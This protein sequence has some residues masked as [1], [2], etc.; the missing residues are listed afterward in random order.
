VTLLTGAG[1]GVG[2]ADPTSI[3]AEDTRY[4]PSAE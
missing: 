4:L 3:L 1:S 2:R